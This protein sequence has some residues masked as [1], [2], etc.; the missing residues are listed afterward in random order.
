ML[1]LATRYPSHCINWGGSEGANAC[2]RGLERSIWRYAAAEAIELITADQPRARSR[3]KQ[4]VEVTAYISNLTQGLNVTFEAGGW[5]CLHCKLSAEGNDESTEVGV[6]PPMPDETTEADQP[7]E[8]EGETVDPAEEL[9]DAMRQRMMKNLDELADGVVTINQRVLTC[10]VACRDPRHAL[11]D[12]EFI[13]GRREGIQT[14]IRL[15]RD[16]LNRYPQHQPRPPGTRTTSDV[17][18][19]STDER[20]PMDAKTGSAA[21]STTRRPKAKV[22]PRRETVPTGMILIR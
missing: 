16:A 2:V 11:E 9:H 7:E 3:P 12:C 1:T 8:E 15:M 14:A 6:A 22:R 4:D 17:P 5:R 21:S 10:C 20:M 19:P 18:M 13:P